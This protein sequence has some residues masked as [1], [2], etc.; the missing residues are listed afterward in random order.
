MNKWKICF[1]MMI[2]SI[3]FAHSQP[4]GMPPVK[5][6]TPTY[7]VPV[8]KFTWMTRPVD[9]YPGFNLFETFVIRLKNDSVFKM[10]AQMVRKDSVIVLESDG[11]IKTVIWPVE[12]IRISNLNNQG[13]SVIGIPVD[14][15]WIFR[16]IKGS[17]NG[18]S[19][20]GAE[21]ADAIKWIQQ[22]DE[23]PIIPLNKENLLS[24]V[25]TDPRILKLV[26]RGKFAKAIWQH[27]NLTD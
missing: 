1:V 12:T 20:T 18:Y 16:V 7:S 17:I 23:G 22:G 10:S 25:G 21:N 24:I 9:Y 5:P 13:Q 11:K 6:V 26:D 2:L 4:F 15:C 27:N 8:Q 3:R 19:L 14:S